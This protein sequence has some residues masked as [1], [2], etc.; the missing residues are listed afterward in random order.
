MIKNSVDN[1]I[2]QLD[3]EL[4]TQFDKA[5]CKDIR[6]SYVYLTDKFKEYFGNKSNF[7]GFTELL[8]HKILEGWLLSNDIHLKVTSGGTLNGKRTYF[9][10][11]GNVK[12]KTQ[13]SDIKLMNGNIIKYY[14]SIKAIKIPQMVNVDS[15]DLNSNIVTDYFN[16]LLNKDTEI[17]LVLQDFNRIENVRHSEHENF[18]ALT[19]FFSKPNDKNINLLNKIKNDYSWYDYICLNDIDYQ[20]RVFIDVINGKLN[21]I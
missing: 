19:I 13:Q 8:I 1:F 5:T 18:K 17:P 20:N 10:K 6:N 4:I 2:Y 3:K 9:D 14:I 21:I 16:E 12:N 7:S 15:G 11:K